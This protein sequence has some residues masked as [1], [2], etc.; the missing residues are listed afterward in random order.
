MGFRPT[1]KRAQPPPRACS[2]C[3]S[4][5]RRGFR[6]GPRASWARRPRLPAPPGTERKATDPEPCTSKYESS[7]AVPSRE[8]SGAGLVAR[9]LRGQTGL[10]TRSRASRR[11]PGRCSAHLSGQLISQMRA[12]CWGKGY[13]E[14][15]S[16]HQKKKFFFKVIIEKKKVIFI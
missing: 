7:A 15:K 5:P 3:T 10:G 16:N 1:R 4:A 8:G 6:E 2:E 14:F 11:R 12:Q 9:R 13:L